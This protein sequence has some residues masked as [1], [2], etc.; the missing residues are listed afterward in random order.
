MTDNIFKQVTQIL[1]RTREATSKSRSQMEKFL[2]T[3]NRLK[4]AYKSTKIKITSQKNQLVSISDKNF[5]LAEAN[6]EL[7]SEITKLK[8]KNEDYKS[9]IRKSKQNIETL[10]LENSDLHRQFKSASEIIDNKITEVE[11][12]THEMSSLR[13]KLGDEKSEKRELQIKLDKLNAKFDLLNE[14]YDEKYVENDDLSKQLTVLKKENTISTTEN[15]DL[16]SNVAK[17]EDEIRVLADDKAELVA[18]T[19]ISDLIKADLELHNGKLHA[20]KIEFES[21][22]KNLQCAGEELK[23]QLEQS[24]SNVAASNVQIEVLKTNN[25]QLSSTIDEIQTQNSELKVK[26]AVL[27]LNLCDYDGR[28]SRV[29]DT[30]LTSKSSKSVSSQ[31]IS[32]DSSTFDHQIVQS[33]K[34][35]LEDFSGELAASKHQND[36]LI[37]KLNFKEKTIAKK[38]EQLANLEDLKKKSENNFNKTIKS[39]EDQLD[40]SKYDAEDNNKQKVMFQTKN[41]ELKKLI[42]AD[43]NQEME[44]RHIGERKLDELRV[45]IQSYSKQVTQLSGWN[46]NLKEVVD[47]LK[48]ENQK[49]VNEK[50]VDSKRCENIMEHNLMRHRSKCDGLNETIKRLRTELATHSDISA[51]LDDCKHKVLNLKTEMAKLKESTKTVEKLSEVLKPVFYIETVDIRT[52]EAQSNIPVRSDLLSIFNQQPL[53]EALSSDSPKS[54]PQN[55]PQNSNIKPTTDNNM[56]TNHEKSSFV[57]KNF[58]SHEPESRRSFLKRD[59]ELS[60]E[61]G[62][63]SG[64][65]GKENESMSIGIGKHNKKKL[66]QRRKS[67]RMTMEEGP[68]AKLQHVQKLLSGSKICSFFEIFRIIFGQRSRRVILLCSVSIFVPKN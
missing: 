28:E 67:S 57:H 44:N 8:T 47:G 21:A 60:T 20:E 41:E 11:K 31:T 26:N 34:T 68:S 36:N 63:E 43:Q 14:E 27:M 51:E 55:S 66:R 15:T 42:S 4:N 37:K 39:L 58:K 38:T 65:Y 50:T 23:L 18:E 54:S 61:S 6:N 48:I 45:Q 53:F 1:Y 5:T 17:L 46:D 13:K 3:H 22:V 56:S 7:I 29:N 30:R 35:Q 19:V 49:L 64:G 52:N 10:E 59:R 40:A 25:R 12:M 16:K 32:A 24:V 62:S 33:L 2:D 9:T